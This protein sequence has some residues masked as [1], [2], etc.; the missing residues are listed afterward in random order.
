MFIWI[1]FFFATP[2]GLRDLISSTRDL[3]WGTA[4]KAPSPNHWT[5]RELSHLD[6]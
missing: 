3:T 6:F 1:F 2:R 5:A 4:V